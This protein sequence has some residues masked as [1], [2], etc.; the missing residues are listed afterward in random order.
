MKSKEKLFKYYPEDFGEL[1]VKVHHMNLVFDIYNKKTNVESEIILEALEDI[2]EITL[3]AHNLEII[4]IKSNH[5]KLN[6]KYDKDKNLIYLK[7]LKEIKKNQKISIF[8]NSNCFPDNKTLEG[9]YHDVTPKGCP[10]QIISQC[11]QWG[12]QRIVPCIDDMTAKC[13]YNTTIKASKD[14]TNYITNGDILE[15]LKPISKSRVEIKYENIKTPMAT[16]LFFLGV[17]TYKT[18]KREF[19]YPN[20]DKFQLEL[21]VPPKSDKIASNRALK[22]LHDAIMWVYLFTGPNKYKNELISK[23]ILKLIEKRE[24]LKLEN[25]SKEKL[26]SI[27]KKLNKLSQDKTFG[28][29]YTGT[30]YR[31]IGMQNTDFGG[32]ENVGNTTISTNR[33]MPFKDMVD[34]IFEYMIRVKVHEYYHNLNGSEVTGKSP[35]EIWLNEAVTVHIEREYLEFLQGSNYSRL[36]NVIQIISH[37]NGILSNDSGVQ[38]I[39]IL[40][41]GFNSPNDL[42]TG[43]TY[44]KAPEFVRMIQKTLGNENFVLGLNDYH[45]KYKHSNAT[46]Q[47]WINSMQKYTNKNLNKMSK[48]W[49]NEPKFPI[50][51]ISEEFNK[52]D[53]KITLLINQINATKTKFWSFPFKIAIFKKSKKLKELD[54]FIDSKEQKIEILGIKDYSFI[55]LNRDFSVYGKVLYEQSIKVLENQIKYDDDIISRFI[56]LQK[57]FDIV[58][59]ELYDDESK[60]VDKEF[61]ELYFNLLSDKK[62]FE[63]T[64]GLFFT[65]FENIDDDKYAFDFKKIYD[66]KNKIFKEFA[67]IYEKKLFKLYEKFNTNKIDDQFSF[68]RNELSNLRYRQV[69]NLIL[70]ILAKLNTDKVHTLIKTQF[71]ESTNATDKYLAFRLYIESSIKDKEKVLQQF[72]NECKKNLV[73][74]EMFLSIIATNN[75]ENPIKL[76][77]EIQKDESFK[78]EQSNDQRS[79]LISF[80]L[81]K[82]ISLQTIEGRKYLKEIIIKLTK[83]NEYTTTRLFS[84]FGNLDLMKIEDQ[85]NLVSLLKQVQSKIDSKKHA[86]VYNTIE[87]ILF[88]SPISIKNW[89]KNN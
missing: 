32:M 2:K 79:L 14:Y 83:V 10:C 72:K 34:P 42:I 9:L 64:G 26:N 60:E 58:K 28:Y 21:L 38:S 3:N 53:K 18:F 33:I 80:A 39:P 19:E 1:N 76:I 15:K 37:G 48:T 62:I 68:P 6:Y 25:N 77:K 63:K 30:I 54:L 7:F 44:V 84:I 16:Y 5:S 55:S 69:K 71:R 73:S 35:F 47:D 13:T 11:Q 52:K 27:R 20:G 74:W 87:R 57:R 65:L 36:N 49:L 89:E 24:K 81:N 41:K 22:V 4:D 29:K 85:I 31:E 66:I 56:S 70:S 8:T 86:I 40:P 61:L 82:K 51:E 59:K 75:S 50:I 43:I 88:K 46:T 45:T 78:I 67:K 12:F 23:E 17:G